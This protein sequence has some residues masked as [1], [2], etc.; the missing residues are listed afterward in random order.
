MIEVYVIESLSSEKLYTG[1]TNNLSRRL[2]EHNQGKS[3]FT[4]AYAPWKLIYSEQHEDYEQ[5]RIREKYLKTAAGKK[6]LQKQLGKTGSLP[7]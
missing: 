3:H 6:F 5:A 2:K 7:D 4:K 1:I